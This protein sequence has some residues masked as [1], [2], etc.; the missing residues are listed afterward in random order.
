MRKI[1]SFEDLNVWQ[2]AVKLIEKPYKATLNLPQEE[3]Y[4][5]VSQIKR[6]GISVASNIADGF[7]R[8]TTKELISFIYMSRGSCGEL[9]CQLRIS[10]KLGLFE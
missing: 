1:R 10:E 5:P 2:D 7:C 4:S 9:I 3:K 8:N 6:A